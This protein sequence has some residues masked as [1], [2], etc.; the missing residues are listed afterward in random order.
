[1]LLEKL[2]ITCKDEMRTFSNT[3]PQNKL[4]VE[5]RPKYKSGLYKNLR[6]KPRQNTDKNLSNMF[7][8]SPPGVLIINKNKQMESK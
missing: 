3:I 4:K 1:M 6:G 7:L 8:D 2:E 5:E